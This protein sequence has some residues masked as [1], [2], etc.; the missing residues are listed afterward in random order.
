MIGTNYSDVSEKLEHMG[1]TEDTDT[2][3]I[4][5]RLFETLDAESISDE[6]TRNVAATVFSSLVSDPDSVPGS[7]SRWTDYQLGVTAPG[8]TVRVRRDAYNGS[9]TKHNGLVGHIV[10]IRGGRVSVQYLGRND[11][12]GHS[13]HP[14]F[15]EV[16]VK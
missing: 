13:H 11:G 12:V 4:I 7:L 5:V 16:L 6:Q 1:Y 15:L 9:G 3:R 14:D 2:H 10:G 8:D